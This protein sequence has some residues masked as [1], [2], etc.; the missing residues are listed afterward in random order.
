MK[1]FFVTIFKRET[2]DCPRGLLSLAAILQRKKIAFKNAYDFLIYLISSTKTQNEP[3]RA[4]FPLC[5]IA[6]G[7]DAFVSHAFICLNDFSI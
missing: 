5:V 2:T 7:L 4:L 1:H 6:I 3:Q